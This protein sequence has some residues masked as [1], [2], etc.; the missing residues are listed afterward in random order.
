MGRKL[1]FSSPNEH[2]FLATLDIGLCIAYSAQ[3]VIIIYCQEVSNE[4]KINEQRSERWK[5]N[6]I[7]YDKLYFHH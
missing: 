5:A 6:F 3:I 4:E 1:C 7:M 2:N